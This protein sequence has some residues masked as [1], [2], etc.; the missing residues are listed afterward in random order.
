MIGDRP[1]VPAFSPQRAPQLRPLEL[2]VGAPLGSED[3]LPPSASGNVRADRALADELLSALARP[4]CV[5]AFSGGRD[6][7]GIL[8][9]AAHVARREGLPEPI[10]ATW[11]FPRFPTSDESGWQELVVAHL[12]LR[13]W[14]RLEL[15][16]E[17]DVLGEVATN[18]LSE[19]GLLWPPNAHLFQPLVALAGQGSLVTGLGGDELLDGWRWARVNAVLGGNVRPQARDLM[20]L[21]FAITPARRHIRGASLAASLAESLAW[22]RPAAI[23]QL[24]D[25]LW[26]ADS[27]EP[28]TWPRRVAWA[29]RRRQ[30]RLAVGGLDLLAAGRG[31]TVHHPLLAPR[32]LAAIAGEGRAASLGRPELMRVLFETVLPP[33]ALS[34][35]TKADVTQVIWGRRARRF[36]EA[37]T[38]DGIADE[39]VD[40]ERLRETWLQARP[41]YLAS[42]LMRAA[43][44]GSSRGER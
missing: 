22:L 21:A 29:T 33:A 10:P 44:L 4:P 20:R 11:R 31:V 7:S 16:E 36:A 3:G 30:V 28:R 34:R 13:A 18:L 37:W 8:A 5:V 25:F 32:F 39:L 19:H 6:S 38:G 26:R 15:D 35:P 41:P 14:E 24:T 9:L 17:A 23:D 12:G 43:W 27:R 42:T 40:A 2:A 1:G